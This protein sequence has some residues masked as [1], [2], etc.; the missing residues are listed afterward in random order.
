MVKLYIRGN[1]K[2]L[3]SL[4]LQVNQRVI[5]MCV[6]SNLKITLRKD[7]HHV[8]YRKM[9]VIGYVGE[10]KMS[11]Q[12]N[13]WF[14]VSAVIFMVILVT[15]L[16]IGYSMESKRNQE[17][18][19]LAIYVLVADFLDVVTAVTISYGTVIF[20]VV[21][22][23][24]NTSY[25]VANVL[26]GYQFLRYAK[27]WTKHFEGETKVGLGY[28]L[29]VQGYLLLLAINLFTGW[30][31][32]FDI[33]GNYI[34][35]PLY[36]LLSAIPY[37]CFF[38]GV[39]QM[40]RHTK[41]YT[42]Q[43]RAS[44]FAFSLLALSGAVLQIIFMPE[45]L[46]A[47]FTLSLGLII[48]LFSLETPDYQM[49]MQAMEELQQAKTEA[50]EAKKK[51]ERA[52]QFKT[53]F[54][55][56]MSHEIRTPINAVLGMNEMILRE[57]S[58]MNILEYAGNIQTAGAG[59]LSLIN[60]I[61]DISKIESGK[62]E[63]VFAE[64]SLFQLLR[65]CYNMM[66]AQMKAKNLEF[67]VENESMIPDALYGDELRIRQVI[68]NLLTNACKYTKEGKVILRVKHRVISKMEISLVI[69][70]EDTGIGVAEEDQ[71]YLFDTFERFDVER[72]RNIEGAGLGLS[73]TRDLVKL[74]DG[75][76]GLISTLNEGSLFYVEI[77]QRVVKNEP[78]GN[79]YERYEYILDVKKY[80]Q[81]WQAKEGR[82][83]VVDDVEVN[84]IV[85]ESLLK[86]TRVQVDTA[87]S[88][89][90]CLEK[91]AKKEY[92]MILLDHMMPEMDGIE[93]LHKLKLQ[94]GPNRNT[95]VIVSTAN[96]VSG[97]A[98]EY[99]RAGFADYLMKPA[100]GKELEAMVLKYLPKE[101]IEKN[102][103]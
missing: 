6:K 42:K 31:F 77:P 19:K 4:S 12:Y 30:M 38:M 70:V 56:N 63:L 82:I 55:T 22:M 93:S 41:E 61:L 43:Q 52:S 17:F 81:E 33:Q 91:A 54:L 85:V 95:P 25:F 24:L 10:R 15:Y 47:M 8:K 87:K 89:A 29:L 1:P 45:V 86:N 40:I 71:K 72:N 23:L 66:D 2:N 51:A 39:L 36:Y 75:D 28:R 73:I 102:D 80:T 44:I 99:L 64:Y 83:L 60:D 92:H 58:E 94:K 48:I 46:L 14:G 21:N 68:F 11:L 16:W 50:E 13:I 5:G 96:A 34:H 78:M 67:V 65:D 3:E 37:A 62:M 57:S 79:F 97:A 103:Y 100:T 53:N 76:I 27:F 59:L 35:G 74:M 26:L 20:P 88:G 9:G 98:E 84:L 32:D 90:E 69:A 18:F 7:A 49:L 101:L